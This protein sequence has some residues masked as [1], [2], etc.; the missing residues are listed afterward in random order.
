MSEFIKDHTCVFIKPI[1]LHKAIPDD[2]IR[3][4]HGEFKRI[5]IVDKQDILN[6]NNRHNALTYF[7]NVPKT[8]YMEEFVRFYYYNT[9]CLVYP[10][11]TSKTLDEMRNDEI[12]ECVR[13]NL[14]LHGHHERASLIAK[15]EKQEKQ[16]GYQ[17]C[18]YLNNKII[19]NLHKGK[20]E[21]KLRLFLDLITRQKKNEL[22]TK[23]QEALGLLSRPCPR[24]TK[25]NSVLF[26]D[27]LKPDIKLYNYQQHDIEWM[28]E[29]TEE[30][31]RNEN[32]I[33]Y[34]YPLTTHVLDEQFVLFNNNV[35]PTWILNEQRVTGQKKIRFFGGSLTSQVGLG[36]TIVSLFYL[37]TIGEREREKYNRFVEFKTGSC[38]YMY[39]RGARSGRVCETITTNNDLF[40][41]PHSKTPFIDK[42]VLTL[43]NLGEFDL[44]NFL[45]G[46]LLKTNGSLIVCPNQ[47]CDQWVREYY[48]KF[49]NDKRVLLVVTKDQFKNLTVADLLFADLVVV[50]YQFLSNNY[51]CHLVSDSTVIQRTGD[52]QQ[53]IQQ[54][55][56]DTRD[57]NEFREKLLTS[58]IL[59]L[60]HYF[61]WNAV[62]LDETHEIQNNVKGSVIKSLLLQLQSK[63]KWNVTGTPFANGLDGFLALAQYNTDL[64]LRCNT[65]NMNVFDLLEEG[66]NNEL[67]QL[68]ER[69]YRCNTK[70]SVKQEYAGNII[71]EQLHLLTF[72][73]QER[74]VYD[75]HLQGARNKYSD[76][77]I[78]LCCHPELYNETREL[79]QNC[80][81][82]GEIQ[83]VML[84]YNHR[85]LNDTRRSIRN[86][87][88]D[89]EYDEQRL[90]EEPDVERQTDIKAQIAINK[91]RLTNAKTILDSVQ[92]T[93][94]YLKSA[95]DSIDNDPEATCPICLDVIEE[96]TI[97]KCG[98]KFCWECLQATY[99]SKASRV[100][101]VKCPTCNQVMSTSEIYKF[102]PEVKS[103]ESSSASELDSIVNV[104]KS[105][106]IGNIIFYLKGLRD[107]DSDDKI[108]LFSQ[109]D[110]LLH[111]VGT[112]LQQHGLNVVYCNGTVYQRKRAITSF[113]KHTA[114]NN[115]NIIMLSS[116]NAAS[117]INLTAA[118][119]IVLLEPVYGSSD[120]R[121]NI[122]S[123][124]IGRADR[125]GQQRPIQVHRFII[126]DTIEHDIINNNID[127]TAIKTMH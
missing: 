63:Y 41:K 51:Y 73:P 49:T 98:H 9:D 8:V 83:N 16:G 118:N 50:S 47:L 2:N 31:D 65:N 109:W 117:G 97:T 27:F 124:A 94:N 108:I 22:V 33:E 113:S 111:K 125:I 45:K 35:Y 69:L 66:I 114:D 52:I 21:P 37:F 90:S 76:F 7:H 4:I 40:C 104:V 18:Y 6:Y 77:L 34:S 30:V 93:F 92:R 123:Q 20:R 106:K 110:E 102:K 101:E 43:R 29:L 59:T 96:L 120:Y 44:Q 56:N 11:L 54:L 82:L 116:R 95:I 60:F 15:L 14:F 23:S 48:N 61:N 1:V 91:R 79:I 80:K 13:R 17:M 72:T 78:R 115:I 26:N 58:K 19:N 36:K 103:V 85:K 84:D 88:S 32:V 57:D 10:Y 99:S 39:K 105:T 67:V 46:G 70:E 71:G 107:S 75:S 62:L 38:N 74:S 5:Y 119:K 68:S 81:T 55:Q 12:Q 53:K 86:I 87:Q 64:R 100:T 127:D 24:K 28:L 112:Y 25:Q 121:S 122:E 126:K 3:L 42:Q 89:I